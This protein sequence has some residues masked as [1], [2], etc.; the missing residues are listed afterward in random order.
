MGTKTSDVRFSDR[1]AH[2]VVE[3][4]RQAGLDSRGAEPMR[5]GENALFHLPQVRAVARIARSSDHWSDAVKEVEVARWLISNDVPACPLLDVPQPLDVDGF[6]V[7]FWT[8]IKGRPGGPGDV[9][10]L[11]EVLRSIHGLPQP[12]TFALSTAD[13]LARVDK[14]IAASPIPTTDKEFLRR[15]CQQLR[16]RLTT[17]SFPLP[18]AAVHGDA[19]VQNLIFSNDGQVYVIDFER[20]IWGQPEWDLAMT[21]TEYVTAGWWTRPEYEEFVDS[22]GGFDIIQW[23]GFEVLRSV[24]ELKMTT[25]IMQNVLESQDVAQE[26]RTRM[27]TLRDGTQARDWSPF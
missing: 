13:I 20:F 10:T 6:P 4:C 9:G 16:Q 5:L 24:H 21:A 22:Y 25:W 3:A 15:R 12:S 1:A 18:P 17:L 7:T 27:R 19:H 2:I 23:D 14:R 8:F 26:Y 11:G